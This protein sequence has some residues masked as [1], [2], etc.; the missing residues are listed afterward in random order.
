MW[1]SP[2]SEPTVHGPLLARLVRGSQELVRRSIRS[3]RQPGHVG[4]NPPRLV[5]REQVGGGASSRLILIVDVAQ[6]LPVMVTDNETGVVRLINCP[7]SRE[8]T[9][10][11]RH[12]Q[13][14][15]PSDHRSTPSTTAT[16]TINMAVAPAQKLR[17]YRSCRP[18]SI[19]IQGGRLPAWHPLEQQHDPE[20]RRHFR[21]VLLAF[22][23]TLE[24]PGKLAPAEFRAVF[25]RQ[26]FLDQ[27]PDVG[28]RLELDDVGDDDW[29]R[30]WPRPVRGGQ[31]RS[32]RKRYLATAD[33]VIVSTESSVGRPAGHHPERHE[34]I[35]EPSR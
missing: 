1:A 7:R 19:D 14:N 5:T 28:E 18:V 24:Q 25:P 26:V 33:I 29:A 21:H 30:Q 31:L 16:A 34:P 12:G 27:D 13:G 23:S 4:R 22:N 20:R 3:R 2:N 6:R 11:V 15:L 8:A 17:S 35:V 9:G 32:S 10:T